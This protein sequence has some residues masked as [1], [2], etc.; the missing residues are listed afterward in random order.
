[1][2]E[3]ALGI[4]RVDLPVTATG[5]LAGVLAIAALARFGLTAEGAIVAAALAVLVLLA[6]IDLRERRIPNKIVLPAAA[7]ALVAQSLAMPDRAPEWVLSAGLA[8]LILLIAALVNPGGIGM[9]D[10]KL[11]LLLGAVLGSLVVDAFLVAFVAFV[12]FA[13]ILFVRRGKAARK[14]TIPLGP[15][16]AFGAAL[17]LLLAGPRGPLVEVA[18]YVETAP[19]AARGR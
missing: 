2:N 12:P 18:P 7:I 14:A 10:V 13:V 5:G 6:A 4:P 9:G 8:A 1:M 16:L 3:H 17:I 11:A 15:F 19:N